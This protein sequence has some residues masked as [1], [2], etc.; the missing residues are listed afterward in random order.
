M[1]CQPTMRSIGFSLLLSSFPRLVVPN[2]CV[3][4]GRP[5]SR[6]CRGRNI[7]SLRLE[8]ERLYDVCKRLLDRDL[9]GTTVKCRRFWRLSKKSAKARVLHESKEVVQAWLVL[10]VLHLLVTV[11]SRARRFGG[12]GFCGRILAVHNEV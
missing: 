8:H 7:S 6:N 2:S 11:V 12:W 4:S 1:H 9:L 5:C 10:D 3:C